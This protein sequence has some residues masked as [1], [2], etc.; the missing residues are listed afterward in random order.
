M[1]KAFLFFVCFVSVCTFI[2]FRQFSAK[3]ESAR[4]IE[5]SAELSNYDIR[6]E[7]NEAARQALTKFRE[8][9]GLNLSAQEAVKKRMRLGE[10]FLR[11]RISSL[12]IEYGERLQTP[13]VVSVD[14]ARNS[15][16]EWLTAP[17]NAKRANILRSFIK[18]NS[19]LFGLDE[20]QINALKT[21]ADYTNPDGNL[22]FAHLEQEINGLRVFQG[23]VKAGFTKK[24]EIV[25]VINNL[26]PSLDYQNLSTEAEITAEQAV[27]EAAKHINIQVDERD[28]KR[29]ETASNDKKARFE[30]GRFADETTAEKIYFPTEIG[31]A[32]LAW[33][34]LLWQSSDAFDI[35]VDAQDGTLLWRKNITNYQTQAAT[36]NVYGN[37]SSLMKISDS[38]T[39]GTPGCTTPV[40][41]VP[42]PII[43]RTSFTLVGN[44]PPYNFN[45]LGWIPDGENRTNGNNAE[46][47]IDRDGVNGVDPQ[48]YAF[49]SPNRNFV[50]SYNPAP[51]DPAPGDE[52]LPPQ[53]Q[54]Y[55]PSAFQQGSVTNAF[56][57]TNRFHDELYRL[58]FTEQAR[59]FQTDNF[60][61]GGAGN[62]S[63]S[64]EVQ[65]SSGTN[66]ANFTTTPDGSRP[67]LQLY[68]WTAPDPDRDGALDNQQIVHELT[69]GVSSRLHGNGSGLGSAM[70]AGMGEGW[71]DF[72]ALALLYEQGDPLLATYPLNGY[73]VFGTELG[74]PEYYY[75]YHRFPTAVRD[76]IRPS[77]ALP[78][79]PLTLAHLNP[80]NCA[81]F[82][83]AFP[84]RPGSD[85]TNCSRT[86]YIGEVWTAALWEARGQLA[87]AYGRDEGNRRALQYVMD[88]MKLAPLNPTLFQERDAML[89][90]ANVGGGMADLRFVWR[91]FATR[92]LG[93]N[94]SLN[95]TNPLTFSESFFM[96]PQ[97]RQPTRADFDGDGRTDLSVARANL[98]RWTWY[99]NN[100]TAGFS[101]TQWGFA[102][103]VLTPGDFDGDGKTDLAVFR[104]SDEAGTPDF[105]I[106]NSSN[107]TFSFV[108]WGVT[109]DIP[110]AADYDNDGK[111]DVAVYRR[112]NSSFYALKS[113]TGELLAVSVGGGP[114]PNG[115]PL[116][117]DFDGD[118]KADFTY[119]FAPSQTGS[120]QWW[121]RKS[122]NNY[123]A[124]FVAFGV[125]SDKIVPADYDGDSRT[126]I[127]VYRPSNGT[128]YIRRSSQ[129]E[130]YVQFGDSTD[131]PVPGDY[132]GDGRYDIAV[133]RFGTWYVLQSTAGFSGVPFGVNGDTPIP[134]GYLP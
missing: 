29:I 122:L 130:N 56:Y 17:D 67:R 5:Q 127:A 24:G 76:F 72:F 15:V 55:P 8:Q 4:Q 27:T 115:I 98:N 73:T 3:V 102:T 134:K 123:N 60:G 16:D 41:C 63:I 50:Y 22:S 84:P 79:N 47:G 114:T 10:A 111:T 99:L 40:G 126:D 21:T 94:A 104:A 90:A 2:S 32:R 83:S 133:Y 124:D 109:S 119:T 78:H 1:K 51:G 36:Y 113:S 6:T 89:T 86:H 25:R 14:V 48:G 61:R 35:I 105:Y 85:T 54:T 121:M 77:N 118:G 88:G 95:N 80:G 46:A 108:S 31:A 65:D 74:V 11:W 13:E 101:A 34:I 33:R 132:D 7:K 30:R 20:R 66:N 87:Q 69:H 120:I 128:W 70:A 58:G 106:L 116:I 71:S 117:G 37:F 100:S 131:I 103:D 38:P 52:P 42:P 82:Q 75:G 12:N 107:S 43:S 19:A 81:S 110:I 26:A 39:P 44:E 125:G 23:E 49:G 129:G 92:G 91:G 93:F 97:F 28:T 53:P 57:V 96:P 62:D 59:N 64:V 18:Q 68:V 112:S 45:N 9:A